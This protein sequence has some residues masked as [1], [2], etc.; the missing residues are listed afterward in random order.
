MKDG[1]KLLPNSLNKIFLNDFHEIN[2]AK[3]GSF[4][5]YSMPINYSNG[6]IKEHLHTRK[7]IGVFDVSHM[8][9]ILIPS[10]MD[11]SKELEKIIPLDIINLKIN[12]SFYSFILNDR[13]GIIDDLIISKIIVDNSEYFFIVYNSSRKKIDEEIFV[14]RTNNYLI[15]KDHSLLAIQGPLSSKMMTSFSNEINKMYFM[16]INTFIFNNHTIIISRTGYTGEDGFELSIPNSIITE[17]INVLMRFNNTLLCG[18]GCRDTLRLEAG[19]SLYGN[20]LNEDLT[21][22]EANL[23]WAISK[24]RFKIGSFNGFETILHQIKHGTLQTRIGV[25]SK[26]KSIL[27]SNMKIFNKNEKIIGK[28]TSGGFSPTL[29]T[30]IAIGYIDKCFFEERDKLYCLIRNNIEEIEL[31]KLPFV[32]HNYRRLKT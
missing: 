32:K 31:T 20:E 10:S 29:N 17:F 8:G 16:Q 2:G 14:K 26:N 28:I 12:N 27:R 18:L 24:S 5:G 21:P 30:S 3:F 25:K 7:L 9:Q 1:D 11:N 6:I 22:V 4:A 13:G 23:S 15:L 19:L